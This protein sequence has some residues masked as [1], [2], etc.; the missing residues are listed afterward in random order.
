MLPA[1]LSCLFLL[2]ASLASSANGAAPAAMD[3][4]FRVADP[5]DV[6]MRQEPLEALTPVL[7]DSEFPDTTSILLFK[8]GRLVFERYLGSGGPPVLNDTRS[9]TKTITALVV[10][11]AI[12][13]GALRSTDEPAFDRLRDL[14]PFRHDGALKRAITIADLLTMSSA[15]DCDDFVAGN[16]GNEENMYPLRDWSRWAADLPVKPDYE[17]S[18]SGRG[19]FSYCTGG[20]LLLGQIVQRAAGQP[21]D[22]Y[23]DVR[24]FQPLGIRERQWTR[25]PSGEFQSGGGLRLRS[26]DLLKLGVLLLDEGRWAGRQIIPADWV[27]TMLSPGNRV[28]EEQAYGMLVWQREYRSPCGPVKGWYMGGNG[29]NIVLS[30]EDANLVAVIT[31]T[32]YNR[33][34]MHEQTTRMIEDHVL[35][36]LACR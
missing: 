34:G 19:P 8:D 25:S 23:V 11:L 29:G 26:R 33:R 36:A 1:R 15:L 22:R 17:R 28:N 35:A 7:I 32:H 3:D 9:V 2:V 16:I 12:A 18:T 13:D 24:L 21:L 27:R 10:G 30:V 20:S 4:G 31:R 6:G 5:R 14:A